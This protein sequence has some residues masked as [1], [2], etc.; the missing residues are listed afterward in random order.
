MSNRMLPVHR[1]VR[2][3]GQVRIRLRRPDT[4]AIWAPNTDAFVC[5]VHAES[6]ARILVFY[7][8]TESDRVEV[9]V[10]GATPEVARVTEIRHHADPAEEMAARL[11]DF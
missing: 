6:G 9:D 10:R 4:S 7:E 3:R 11:R 2:L 5:D 8:A 1:L